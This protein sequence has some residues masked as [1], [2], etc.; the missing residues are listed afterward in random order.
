MLFLIT[1]KPC[2]V[3]AFVVSSGIVSWEAREIWYWEWAQCT[4]HTQIVSNRL[5]STSTPN[6][7]S[8]VC[9]TNLR[10][11]D[12]SSGTCPSL[13]CP[14][15]PRWRSEPFSVN[16]K[17]NPNPLLGFAWLAGW[18]AGSCSRPQIRLTQHDAGKNQCARSFT[19]SRNSGAD[20]PQ[21]STT[22]GRGQPLG[23][24]ALV[25]SLCCV[26]ARNFNFQIN[27]PPNP[28][29]TSRAAN[30]F[31][32]LTHCALP[33]A[34]AVFCCRSWFQFLFFI[35]LYVLLYWSHGDKQ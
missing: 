34:L 30:R 28:C 1:I 8:V 17:W 35:G 16:P 12:R 26:S 29:S 6:Q 23:S 20:W 25:V 24:P 10:W 33:Q 32:P 18:L 21:K 13:S 31:Q 5:Q 14:A 19:F 22:D 11:H 15:F 9:P 2:N 3:F 7:P 4:F 27:F